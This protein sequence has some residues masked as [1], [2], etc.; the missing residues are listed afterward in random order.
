MASNPVIMYLDEARLT[1]ELVKLSAQEAH[2]IT[3][4]Y[5][6]EHFVID[7][8]TTGDGQYN[9]T[10]RFDDFSEWHGAALAARDLLRM[11]RE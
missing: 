8:A 1:F 5:Y 6:F 4:N 2:M 11:V 3:S 7:I 10:L 9:V